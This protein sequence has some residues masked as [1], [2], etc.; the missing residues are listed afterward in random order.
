M[1][2][3]E[4]LEQAKRIRYDLTAL[5]AKVT[6]L[7]QMAARLPEPDI[8][9]RTCPECGLTA[10]ALPPG[11]TLADHLHN[12]HGIDEDD[13]DEPAGSTTAAPDATVSD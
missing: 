8:D 5:Q 7:L 11:V 12:V 10:R 13:P 2:D 1:P 9:T 3:H 4:I 6:E